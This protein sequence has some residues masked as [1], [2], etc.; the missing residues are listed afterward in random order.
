MAY[1]HLWLVGAFIEA[2]RISNVY[3]AEWVDALGLKPI[4]MRSIG[5][6]PVI[7]IALKDK[8]NAINV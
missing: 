2:K 5:S 1:K 3:L 7:N 6:S 8:T 4:F